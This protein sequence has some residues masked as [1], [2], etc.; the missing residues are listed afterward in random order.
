MW[1]LQVTTCPTIKQSKILENDPNLKPTIYCKCVDDCFLVVESHGQ[2]QWLI[3][4]FRYNI[5]LNFNS[6]QSL[7]HSFYSLDVDVV[8]KSWTFTT[9][10]YKKAVNSW[11]YLH[12][13]NECPLIHKDSTVRVMIPRTYEIYSIVNMNISLFSLKQVFVNSGYSNKAFD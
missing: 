2:L 11:F 4:A 8:Q 12:A 10:F 7:N 5:V 13:A 3:K 9:D 1:I 6:E